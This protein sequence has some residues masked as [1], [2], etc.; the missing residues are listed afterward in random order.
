VIR[1]VLDA[2]ALVSGLPA[3]AGT[4]AAIIDCWRSGQFQL[5]VSHHILAEVR[6]AWTKPY[7]QA[8]FSPTLIERTLT[9][10]HDNADLTP[11]TATVEGVATHPE[12]DLVLATAVSGDADYLITG[13]RQLQ[14]LGTFQGVRILS[15]RQFLALLDPEDVLG[16]K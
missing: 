2:N 9:L 7:W 14:R 15:P 11:L 5:V 4:L 8:R 6:R 16:G 3:S 12:D 13:D 1:A 10:L